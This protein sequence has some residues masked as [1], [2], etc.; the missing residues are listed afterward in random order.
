M[1]FKSRT[2]FYSLSWKCAVPLS[3]APAVAMAGMRSPAICRRNGALA[4]AGQQEIFFGL[5]GRQHPYYLCRVFVF[6]TVDTHMHTRHTRPAGSAIPF[7]P[8]PFAGFP[9]MRGCRIPFTGRT[10]AGPAVIA[11]FR[12]WA[13][14]TPFWRHRLASVNG[15]IGSLVF[16]DRGI[17]GFGPGRGELRALFL[18][19]LLAG[20]FFSKHYI[21]HLFI[22][23]V[24]KRQRILQPGASLPGHFPGRGGFL[25]IRHLYRRHQ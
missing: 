4:R 13:I 16:L 10:T 15:S 6:Y 19:I 14:R 12:T 1:R 3:S 20:I 24:G 25:R 7:C 9:A 23:F 2:P 18:Y 21:I 22:L 11:V 17:F 8:E 5:F